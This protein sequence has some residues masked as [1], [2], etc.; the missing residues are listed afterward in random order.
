MTT[1]N[2]YSRLSEKEYEE[3]T[4][5][6]DK[7]QSIRFKYGEPSQ[8]DMQKI[9]DQAVRENR[10]YETEDRAGLFMYITTMRYTAH[11]IGHYDGRGIDFEGTDYE[12]KKI[13]VRNMYFYIVETG[14]VI[15]LLNGHCWFNSELSK[16]DVLK[17][18][19][20]YGRTKRQQIVYM[21]HLKGLKY[22]EAYKKNFSPDKTKYQLVTANKKTRAGYVHRKLRSGGR[23]YEYEYVREHLYEF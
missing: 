16:W 4:F 22:A 6:R 7:V 20:Q 2:I 23:S 19:H 12:E 10:V 17:Y 1:N 9:I 21:S 14:E 13:C 8:L 5:A 11:M 15:Y 18:F 3:Y